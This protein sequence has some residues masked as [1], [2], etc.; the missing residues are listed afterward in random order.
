MP[1]VSESAGRSTHCAVL[2][3]RLPKT[4]LNATSPELEHVQHTFP[5]CSDTSCLSEAKEPID[6]SSPSHPVS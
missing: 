1:Y 2:I 6:P 4:K 5:T 3:T